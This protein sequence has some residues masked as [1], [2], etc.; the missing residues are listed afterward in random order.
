MKAASVRRIGLPWGLLAGIA[1]I[2]T[3]STPASAATLPPG[4]AETRLASGMNNVTTMSLA[5]DGRIFVS[6]QAGRLR[7]IKDEAL[8]AAPALTL[9]VDATN[10]RGLLG[11]AFDPSFAQTGFIYAYYTSPTPVPH[12]RISRFTMNGDVVTAGS[13]VTLLDL[14][15]LGLAPIHNG[16]SMHVGTDGKLYISVGENFNAPN[17][18]SLGTTLGKLLRINLDGTIPSDNPFFDSLTGDNRA[19]WAYGLRNPYTFDIQPG[20]GRI[21]VN[22]VG[23]KLFDEIDEIFKGANYGWPDTEGPHDDPRFE[24]PFYYQAWSPSTC[25][26]I[27]AAFYDPI[28]RDFP[29]AYVGKYFFADLCGGYIKTLDP[30]TKEVEG[31]A[32]GLSTPVDLDVSPDGKLYYLNRGA[33][34]GTGAVFKIFHSH[35]A[36]TISINPEDQLVSDGE[37]ATFTCAGNGAAP[38]A[39]QWAR[40]GVP[41]AGATTPTYSFTANLADDGARFGCILSNEDGTAASNEA[42]LHVVS[43]KTPAARITTPPPGATYEGGQTLFFEGDAT[44]AEDGPLSSSQL[45]WEIV[46]DHDDHSHPGLGPISGI[47][48]GSYAISSIGETSTHVKYRIILRAT[49]STGLVRKVERDVRPKISTI[50]LDTNPAGRSLKLDGQPKKGPL[51]FDGVVGIR[52]ILEAPTFQQEAEASPVWYEFTSWSDGGAAVHE[53][54]TPSAPTTYTAAFRRIEYP[55]CITFETLSRFINMPFANQTGTFMVEFDVTPTAFP[56]NA[57]VG[58]SDRP[59]GGLPGQAALV[60][61]GTNGRVTGRDVTGGRADVVFSYQANV[62]YHVRMVID[63]GA[64]QY[65]VYVSPAGGAEILLAKTLGFR[66]EH[67]LI[68]QLNNWGVFAS[69]NASGGTLKVCH[70]EVNCSGDRNTPPVVSPPP[71]VVVRTGAGA[72]ACSRLVSDAELGQAKT[73]DNCGRVDLV[74]SGVPAGNV[75]PVGTTLISYTATDAGGRTTTAVQS[76]TVI[77]DTAPVIANV[78][79]D[80]PVLSPPNHHMVD[81]SVSYDATDNC[82]TVTP[83]L[84]VTSNEPVD[85]AGD[86]HTSP[87]WEVVDAHHVRLRAERS[88]FGNGRIYTIRVT[89]ADASGN[90]SNQATAVAVPHGKHSIAEI[91]A[92]LLDWLRGLLG[93]GPR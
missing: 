29:L 2:A 66:V 81:V 71:D 72:T 34:T 16:G 9:S 93:L 3:A 65:D 36:P 50:V 37:A 49:D 90:T 42:I 48:S 43:N 35:P 22:D 92:R 51:T 78:A 30:E 19:I 63:L 23:D 83:D 89:A 39:Y 26:L 47:T 76:V 58:L 7:V 13:E 67:A 60:A 56:V 62:T 38:L 86:G 18:Q 12:N 88:G 69:P 24:K 44:D 68:T 27:G 70:F 53:I 1:C 46:F 14:P 54:L 10:E 55:E 82:G 33:G 17:A 52:R 80:K 41:I 11:I 6:E 32:T 4:F 74:R 45:S 40:G 91:I 31:F 25:T 57:N 5:P 64:H 79:V 21:F 84:T 8:L 77:D 28:T 15:A 61:F 20:T 85:G 75:F 87:D 59:R 73:T